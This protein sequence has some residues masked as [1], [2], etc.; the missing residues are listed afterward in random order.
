VRAHEDGEDLTEAVLAT[1][2]WPA[3]RQRVEHALV[4]PAGSA[5][6]SSITWSRATLASGRT[7]DPA[8]ISVGAPGELAQPPAIREQCPIYRQLILE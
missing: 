3:L 5:P 8:A 1:G 4:S 6:I 7:V 2:G